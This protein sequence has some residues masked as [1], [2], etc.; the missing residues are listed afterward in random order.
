MFGRVRGYI[1]GSAVLQSGE[2]RAA[3]VAQMPSLEPVAVQLLGS[4]VRSMRKS[5]EGIVGMRAALAVPWL[6]LGLS[7]IRIVE[8][9]SRKGSER[10]VL[11]EASVT[12]WHIHRGL[13]LP[14]QEKAPSTTCIVASPTPAPDRH[15][16]QSNVPI[17]P[18][19][20]RGTVADV[21]SA[22]EQASPHRI[23]V[24]SQADLSDLKVKRD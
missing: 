3:V 24:G 22:F 15:D 12:G 5:Q 21:D 10:R 4:A 2:R 20:F 11:A 9:Q 18:S 6:V 17:W 8:E 19:T 1:G 16:L 14:N 13:H 7:W 23:A